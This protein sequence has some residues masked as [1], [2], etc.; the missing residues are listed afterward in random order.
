MQQWHAVLLGFFLVAARPWA[1]A[2]TLP[3]GYAGSDTCKVCHEDIYNGPAKNPHHALAVDAK[4][5][6]VGRECEACHGPGQKHTEGPSPADIK[7]PAN[8]PA[9]AADK[10]CL[11]CHLNQPTQIGR[12]ESSHAHNLSPARPVTR[13]TRAGRWWFARPRQPT[14]C[15][16][17]ATERVGPVPAAFPSQA[18]RRQHELRGLPQSAWQ[19][20]A[21]YA[22]ELRG[23]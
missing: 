22:P 14:S 6:W 4:K 7:N 21:G 20:P 19:H 13:C 23:Q 17:A 10:I 9:A 12:L 1:A 3:A 18:P 8:L 2:Q 5:G 15:A 11:T 16:Q